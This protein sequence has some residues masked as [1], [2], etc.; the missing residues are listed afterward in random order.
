MQIRAQDLPDYDMD[1]ED[2]RFFNEVLKDQKKFEV[3]EVT[4]EDMLDRLEKNSGHNVVSVKEAKLLLKE[5]DDLIL[6]VYDYWVDKRLRIKQ[7]L[8]P[9]VKSDKRGDLGGASGG[10]GGGG[11]GSQSSGATANPYVAFRRRTEK[12]QTRKNRKNDEVSYEKMLKLRRDLARAVT[13]LEFVKR[14]EKTKKENLNLTAD[15]FERRFSAADFDGKIVN[16]VL[17]QR[18]QQMQHRVLQP[19]YPRHAENWAAGAALEATKAKRSGQHKKKRH[20]SHKSQQGSGFP[21]RAGASGPEF[22]TSLGGLSSDDERSV[23]ATS[24]SDAEADEDADGPFAFKRRAG[25]QYHAPLLDEH[26]FEIQRGWP[27]EAP[28]EGGGGDPRY[29]YSLASLSTPKPRCVGFVRRRVGRGGRIILDR[30]YANYDEFWSSLGFSIWDS[31][32]GASKDAME[33][34]EDDQV[35]EM[36]HWPHYRPVTPPHCREEPDWDPYAGRNGCDL[37]PAVGLHPL[38]LPTAPV[39]PS[40]AAVAAVNQRIAPPPQSLSAGG[41]GGRIAMMNGQTVRTQDGGDALDMFGGASS[42]HPATSLA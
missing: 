30:N 40:V 42:S 36:R 24:P 25:V 3:N 18:Q 29:R 15:I 1:E 2:E 38:K 17:A 27:W 14:R 9:M 11:G 28:E 6:A 7:P 37:L 19:S 31:G 22:G 5:D 12:M 23:S 32:G 26:G 16:E 13:L 8:I 35:A 34:D 33:V 39:A 41:G 20:K 4:F 10:A 21:G